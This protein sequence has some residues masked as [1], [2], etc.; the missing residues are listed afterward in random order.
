MT[1]LKDFTKAQAK[2][3][4]TVEFAKSSAGYCTLSNRLEIE[5]KM[6]A[7]IERR[8]ISFPNSYQAHVD[9]VAMIRNRLDVMKFQAEMIADADP[10][11]VVID[12]PKKETKNEAKARRARARRLARKNS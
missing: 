8:G 3:W 11:A 6:L 4:V 10:G 7:S 12:A 9:L 1:D 5:K 2:K